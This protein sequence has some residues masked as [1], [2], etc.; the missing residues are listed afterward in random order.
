MNQYIT[1]KARKSSRIRMAGRNRYF[2]SSAGTGYL[3]QTNKYNTDGSLAQWYLDKLQREKELA[4]KI[5]QLR[6]EAEA[7][8]AA[9]TEAENAG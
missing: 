7:K 6:A 4:E 1:K 5:E 8:K 2:K 3:K 9:E